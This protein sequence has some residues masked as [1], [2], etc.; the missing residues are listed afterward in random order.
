MITTGT[1]L[2]GLK[3]ISHTKY[4]DH[5]GS[6]CEIWKNS[7]EMRG[8]YRQLNMATS[9]KNVLRG[10]HRQ[11]QTKLVMPI[12]GE[13]LDVAVEPETGNWFSV[14]LN[15]N[16]AL[17]IPSQYAH[18]YLVLSD[19]AIVQYVVDA[20]HNKVEE[21]SFHWNSYGINWEIDTRDVITSVKDA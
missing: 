10:L 21:E 6:F 9:T 14:V 16:S 13:I 1:F 4:S 3:L 2:P 18:G 15:E 19:T 7:D 20:P 5:R 12:M 11:N 17:L 8:T